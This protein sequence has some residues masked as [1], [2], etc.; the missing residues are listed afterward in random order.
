MEVA[1]SAFC[2]E[3][4][5]LDIRVESRPMNA[6]HAQYPSA[7]SILPGYVLI[8]SSLMLFYRHLN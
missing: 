5:L 2:F 8:P 7:K 1:Q 6:I 4:R 3:R